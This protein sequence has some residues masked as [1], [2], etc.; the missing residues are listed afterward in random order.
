MKR[1]MSGSR[2]TGVPLAAPTGQRVTHYIIAG[3]RH[4]TAYAKLKAT[5]LQLLILG[6][7]ATE[8]STLRYF[9][10]LF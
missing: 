2:P 9:S 7:T 10:R 3:G 6:E 4:A 5:S 1:R 8:P